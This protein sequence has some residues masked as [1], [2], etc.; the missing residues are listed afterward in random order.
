[1]IYVRV[2]G[3]TCSYDAPKDIRANCISQYKL[4]FVTK[5]EVIP[6]PLLKVIMILPWDSPMLQ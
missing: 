1:M 2:T 4:V 5:I 3:S 6:K